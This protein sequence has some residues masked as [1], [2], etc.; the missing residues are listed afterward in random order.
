MENPASFLTAQTPFLP[1]GKVRENASREKGGCVT[2]AQDRDGMGK[3]LMV[4]QGESSRAAVSKGVQILLWVFNILSGEVHDQ[5]YSHDPTKTLF[6]LLTDF[7]TG[8]VEF[9]RACTTYDITTVKNN[10]LLDTCINRSCL[11]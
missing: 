5:N 9:F 3:A 10:L 11:L 8:T 4:V 7:Q 6:D 1:P 2:Q